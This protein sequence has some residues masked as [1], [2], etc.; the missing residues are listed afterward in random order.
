MKALHTYTTVARPLKQNARPCADDTLDV[1][2]KRKVKQKKNMKYYTSKVKRRLEIVPVRVVVRFS[3][4]RIRIRR[5]NA[6][7]ATALRPPA[8]PSTR[9]AHLRD[10]PWPVLLRAF[11]DAQRERYMRDAWL[12]PFPTLRASGRFSL[13]DNR[14]W[15]CS[16]RGGFEWRRWYRRRVY[17]LFVVEVRRSRRYRA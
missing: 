10:T 11:R 9:S 16:R 1:Q 5:N 3:H 7:D 8:I 2:R 13:C 12:L 6:L 14:G 4:P 15:E 17:P